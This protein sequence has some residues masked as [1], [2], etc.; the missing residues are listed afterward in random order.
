MKN[1]KLIEILMQFPLDIDIP[2]SPY[3][4]GGKVYLSGDK[5]KINSDL[6][7]FNRVK[8]LYI[9]LL[10]DI[11]RLTLDKDVPQEVKDKI[12]KLIDR[13]KKEKVQ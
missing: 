6:F 4:I 3:I 11:Y 13:Y 2:C 7:K 5:E 10:A 1:E 9:S 12:G 8:D